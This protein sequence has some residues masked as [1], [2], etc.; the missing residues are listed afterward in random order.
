MN[1]HN[2]IYE[3]MNVFFQ[4]KH[5]VKNVTVFSIFATLLNVP[6]HRDSSILTRFCLAICVIRCFDWSLWRNSSLIQM[7]SWKKAEYFYY[8]FMHSWVLFFDVIPEL[9]NG[10]FLMISFS[11]ESET[12]SVNFVFS[13][14]LKAIGLSCA[15]SGFYLCLVL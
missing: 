15:L 12:W 6:V 10:K 8:P 11:V 14:R 4:S 5:L 7:C 2:L 1:I 13:V 3:S 9:Y